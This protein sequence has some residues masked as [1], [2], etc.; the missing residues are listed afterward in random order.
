MVDGGYGAK[1]L[2]QRIDFEGKRRRKR[3]GGGGGA[4]A[5]G[6]ETFM[7]GAFMRSPCLSPEWVRG[8]GE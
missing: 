6:D 1:A 3:G 5:D 7:E 4:A 2:D 8:S